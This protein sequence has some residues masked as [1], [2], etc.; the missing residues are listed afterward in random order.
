MLKRS[1]LIILLFSLIVQLTEAQL[2]KLKR[3]ELVA[4]LGASQF[5]GDVGGYSKPINNIGLKDITFL[6]TRFDINLNVKYRITQRI[7]VRVSLTYGLLRATDQRGSNEGRGFAAS[8]SFFEPALI[9]EYYFVKNIAETSYL[10]YRGRGKTIIGFLKSL[11]FYTFTGVGG[12]SYSITPNDKLLN[13]GLDPGGFTA[14][15]P[16]GLGSTLSVSPQF[17]FGLEIGGRYAFSDNLDGYTSQYSSSND[18]YYFFNLTVTY[19]LR[20]AKRGSP[21]FRR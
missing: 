18:V 4:G 5:F 20:I 13:H 7:N 8:T 3:Y 14:V 16:V 2:W 10:F 12:L 19:K 1:I 21:S 9:G 15:I 11:D 17:N 6:Q